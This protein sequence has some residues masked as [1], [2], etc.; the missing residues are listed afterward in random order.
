MKLG[1]VDT[2]PFIPPVGGARQAA[3]AKPRPGTASAVEASAPVEL[4]DAAALLEEGDSAA[5]DTR[6]VERIAQLI[7]D[8]KYEINAAAIADKLIANA[9]ELLPRA[10][11]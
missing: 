10:R 3:S 8:G 9:Q 7:R 5:F 1:P 11:H 2:T 6:K 4:S